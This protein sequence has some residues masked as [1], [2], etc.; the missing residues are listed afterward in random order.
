MDSHHRP[1][2]KIKGNDSEKLVFTA[3]DCAVTH[4]LAEQIAAV[5]ENPG[6]DNSLPRKL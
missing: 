1:G 4:K 5:I 6:V 3:Y 2:K